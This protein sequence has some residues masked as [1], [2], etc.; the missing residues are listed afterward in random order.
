MKIGFIYPIQRVGDKIRTDAIRNFL[1]EEGHSVSDLQIYHLYSRKDMLIKY[2]LYLTYRN[3]ASLLN[4]HNF[5]NLYKDLLSGRG[6]PS[7][8]YDIL[9]NDR[10]CRGKESIRKNVKEILNVTQKVEVLHAETHWAAIVC[11]KIKRQI[12][13]PYIF[14]MHGLVADEAKGAGASDSWV[15]FCQ[16]IECE[17]VKNADYVTVVSNL[18]KKYINEKYN[19]S[20]DQ[21]IV[22]P[23]GTKLHPNRASFNLPLKVVYGGNFAYFEGVLDFV[24]IPQ[25]M[26]SDQHQFFLIG[27]GELRNEIFDYINK[28]FIDIIY[29]G[30]KPREK[31]LERFCDMQIGVAPSTKDLVRRVASPIKVLD[32]AACG[33]PIVTVDVGEWSDMI[34]KYDCGIVT[35]NSD[36]QEF[37]TAIEQLRDEKV[38]KQKSDNARTMIQEEY[39]WDK[40][41]EPFTRIYEMTP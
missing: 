29:L 19:K 9:W 39:L 4:P 35:E 18:M 2:I 7:L 37:A 41:L 11:S 27:D 38:W 31:A 16:E 23:N 5:S 26:N 3:I 15:K 34:K 12:G 13:I 8:L 30:K 10:Y 36:P 40:V 20:L 24:K 33:L 28:N 22:I 1:I 21:I 14:D 6:Y 17:A 32:Y 25:I